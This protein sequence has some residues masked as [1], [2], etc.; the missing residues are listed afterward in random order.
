[1]L[2][3]RHRA[4][5]CASRLHC[6]PLPPPLLVVN[7][8]HAA[9][10]SAGSPRELMRQGQG[11]TWAAQ[12]WHGAAAACA[13]NVPPMPRPAHRPLAQ[14]VVAHTKGRHMEGWCQVHASALLWGRRR[15]EQYCKVAGSASA[16]SGLAP[17]RQHVQH[18]GGG[19]CD[20][21][22]AY[23]G[24][25]AGGGQA[26]GGRAN[27]QAVPLPSSCMAAA[28]QPALAPRPPPAPLATHAYPAAMSSWTGG[29]L[30][31]HTPSAAA[32][33]TTGL[34]LWLLAARTMAAGSGSVLFSAL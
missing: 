23:G 30:G 9:P 5:C 34:A 12:Q 4:L 2:A 18:G 31:S 8:A 27:R 6:P 25:R 16:A 13:L 19:G 15:V 20:G 11:G 29:M 28:M 33:R 1:M 22:A 24:G 10:F 32:A 21:V 3:V 26:A 7:A 14:A 17:L